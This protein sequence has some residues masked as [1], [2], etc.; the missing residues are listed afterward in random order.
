LYIL[1]F[2]YVYVRRTCSLQVG[3]DAQR[4]ARIGQVNHLLFLRRVNSKQ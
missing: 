2:I 1:W 4:S 3:S